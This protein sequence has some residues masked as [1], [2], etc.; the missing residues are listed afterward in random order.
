MKICI[1]THSLTRRL[2]KF[3][4]DLTQQSEY[5]N[6]QPHK[7]AD[8]VTTAALQNWRYFN[9]QPHK[10]ADG[11]TIEN[12]I[13]FKDIS[14]HSLTRRLTIRKGLRRKRIRDFNSQPHKE[15]DRFK[16]TYRQSRRISTHSLTRRLTKRFNQ[17]MDGIYI[18]THSL[19][20][21]L[22][23]ETTESRSRP[24]DFNSQPHKEAD[25]RKKHTE[26]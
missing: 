16:D 24:S 5:F 15:A 2:T 18:S 23:K 6:S 9:S 3:R 17:H 11:L 8:A 1:S 10:E 22:T 25:R 14:T 19:T 4:S 20:R 12:R 7:E 21:R 26:S 13:T